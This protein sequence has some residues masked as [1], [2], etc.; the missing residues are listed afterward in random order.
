MPRNDIAPGFTAPP[1]GSCATLTAGEQ[2]TDEYAGLVTAVERVGTLEGPDLG[3]LAQDRFRHRM[4][5]RNEPALLPTAAEEFVRFAS[6]GTYLRRTVVTDT[7]LGGQDLHPG[8]QVLLWLAV[9]WGMEAPAP[10]VAA[11]AG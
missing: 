1:N 6:P 5:L 9:A 8:D 10:K 3:A 7:T 4:R 2:A 11:K